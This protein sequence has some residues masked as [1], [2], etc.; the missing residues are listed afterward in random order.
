[1]LNLFKPMSSSN[2]ISVGFAHNV[3]SMLNFFISLILFLF[4]L[5]FFITCFALGSAV[6]LG[7]ADHSSL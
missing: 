4:D 5:L 1:M 7:S 2:T 3:L 6:A